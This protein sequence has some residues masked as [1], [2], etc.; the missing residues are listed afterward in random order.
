MTSES[1]QRLLE[2]LYVAWLL[3]IGAAHDPTV[4][5]DHLV[6]QDYQGLQ[7]AA[8]DE[9]LG[10]LIRLLWHV[11]ETIEDDLDMESGVGFSRGARALWCKTADLYDILGITR[12]PQTHPLQEQVQ[13]KRAFEIFRERRP[14]SKNLKC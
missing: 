1:A 5:S 4:A 10:I 3:N 12:R 14:F 7:A 2:D 9:S 11:R 6:A 13:G 8:A